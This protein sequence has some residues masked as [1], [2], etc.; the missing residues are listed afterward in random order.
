M[1]RV[2]T[3]WIENDYHFNLNRNVFGWGWPSI[4][5]AL[6][7]SHQLSWN[8]TCVVVRAWIWQS[9]FSPSTSWHQT[10]KLCLIC[11]H[12]SQFKSPHGHDFTELCSQHGHAFQVSNFSKC[13]CHKWSTMT[14]SH[15]ISLGQS[16][17]IMIRIKQMFMT[18]TQLLRHHSDNCEFTFICIYTH[19]VYKSTF[20]NIYRSKIHVQNILIKRGH[21]WCSASGSRIQI[22]LLSRA[23]QN[24]EFIHR[25]T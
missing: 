7:L 8:V 10:A 24:A 12:S 16:R 4:K 21:H 3:R 19:H 22:V 5:V 18:T 23:R 9:N 14:L 20:I 17:L 1:C 2:V 25:S 13:H 6:T 15:H 11:R